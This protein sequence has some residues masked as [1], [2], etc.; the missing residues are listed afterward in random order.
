MLG[1]VLNQIESHPS[2]AAET[3]REA[4]VSLTGV[5]CMGE[6]PYFEDSQRQKAPPFDLIDEQLDLRILETVMNH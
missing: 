5:P 3:N 4:L 6:V 2:L 1:Y